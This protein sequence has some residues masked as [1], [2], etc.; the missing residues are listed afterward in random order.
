MPDPSWRVA[1]VRPRSPSGTRSGPAIRHPGAVTYERLWERLLEFLNEWASARE[2]H[3]GRIQ[4]SWPPSAEH[5]RTIELVMTRREWDDLVTIPY[6]DFD[7]AAQEVKR[8][9]LALEADQRCL[10][11][12]DYELVPSAGPALPPDADDLR[13]EELARQHPEGFGCWVVLDEEGNVID[14]LR[15]PP[16]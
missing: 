8:A 12:R 16:E 5:T 14:E 13:L 3:P 15:P 10:V 1:L 2:V 9:V 7:L 4:V 6:G 11:Y